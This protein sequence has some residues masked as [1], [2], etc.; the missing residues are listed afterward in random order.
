MTIIIDGDIPLYSIAFSVEE[1]ID[2]G[3]DFWTLHSD[4]KMARDSLTIWMDKVV[5]DLAPLHHGDHNL[6]VAL[7]DK[8]NWRKD[9]YPAYKENRVTK[10]KPVVFNPLREHIREAYDA[11]CY[12]RLEADDMLGL[13]AGPEDIMVSSDKDLLTVPGLHYN[14]TK[15]EDGIV[16]LDKAAAFWNHMC[17]TLTGDVT[18]NYKGCP[19]V[20]PKTA[21]KILVGDDPVEMW[22]AVL[23]HFEK[24]GMFKE[25]ALVQAQIAHILH[26]GE[27]NMDTNEVRL[28][29]PDCVAHGV[30][31][32]R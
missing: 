26:P 22:E 2:W 27:Y 13:L 8:A 12:P 9:I 1:P 4:M 3:D 28:W 14:P 18:D 11:V 17:Q 24:G 10:R 7:S 20:G 25:E 5:E 31:A 32:Q 16:R 30:E 6:V 15:P 23:L 29:S 21:R 19:G